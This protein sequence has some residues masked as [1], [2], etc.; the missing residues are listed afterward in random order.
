[1]KVKDPHPLPVK[2]GANVV[3]KVPCTCGKVY[4][5]ETTCQPGACPKEHN[6]K[7]FMDKS[8]IAKQTWKEDHRIH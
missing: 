2:R 7:G 8:A 6:I 1:M 3:Y 5:S 4:N